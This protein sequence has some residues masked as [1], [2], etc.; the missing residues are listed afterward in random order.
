[1]KTTKLVQLGGTFGFLDSCG[2]EIGNKVLS[3][4]KN[5]WE[6][7]KFLPKS[8]KALREFF[9]FFNAGFNDL[10]SGIKPTNNEVKGIIKVIRSLEEYS[11]FLLH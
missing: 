10:S 9:F 4:C 1:M 7:Y 3:G 11:T 8:E 5:F 2:K 6:I